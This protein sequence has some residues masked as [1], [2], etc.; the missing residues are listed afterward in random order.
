MYVYQGPELGLWTVGFYAPSGEWK[1]ESNHAD[2]EDAARR[3]AWLNG[4][5]IEGLK[6]M[7]TPEEK[8]LHDPQYAWLVESLVSL[9][10]QAQFTPSEV[11]EAAMLACIKY[12]MQRPSPHYIKRID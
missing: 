10:R 9:I 6:Q 8:Y 11:R 7:K 2:K 1:P 3:V 4:N 12:E 5:C